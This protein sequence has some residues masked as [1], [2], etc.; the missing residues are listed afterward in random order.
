MTKQD[1]I[2]SFIA[3]LLLTVTGANGYNTDAGAYVFKNLEYT[4]HPEV[5]P[6]IAWFPGDLLTGVEVGP[7]PPEMGEINHMYP[8]SWEG[9]IADDLDGAQ[10]RMLKADLVKALYSDFHFGGLIEIIDGCKSSVA[11][12]AGDEIFSCVQVSFTIFYVTP[13]GQE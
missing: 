3:D 11:V 9:F 12:Q 2:D 1:Q 7:T 13:Y 4:E 5:M 10:G 6:C 8:M